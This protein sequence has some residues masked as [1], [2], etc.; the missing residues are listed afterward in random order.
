MKNHVQFLSFKTRT[1]GQF[2]PFFRCPILRKLDPA[3][4]SAFRPRYRLAVRARH[5]QGPSTILSK[6]TPMVCVAF[7]E[8]HSK[9]TERHLPYG[10]I[11]SYTYQT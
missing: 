10:I 2:A 3:G 5:G 9:A 7:R 4:G 8:T 1:S 6:F 11:Q